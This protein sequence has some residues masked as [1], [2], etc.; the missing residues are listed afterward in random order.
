MSTLPYGMLE[1]SS[2][3]LRKGK[4]NF[5]LIQA[6]LRNA[7][8]ASENIWPCGLMDKALV[9]GTKDCRFESYRGQLL[10]VIFCVQKVLLL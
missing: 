5:L 8:D 2:K 6:V 3:M 9:F 1:A 10:L 4:V 7:V